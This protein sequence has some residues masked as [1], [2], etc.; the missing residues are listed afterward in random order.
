M[1]DTARPPRN[2]SPLDFVRALDTRV[3]GR[4][5]GTDATR[6][7]FHVTVPAA[8]FE[9]MD[10]RDE[11]TGW[12]TRRGLD[13]ALTDD[14]T[15]SYLTWPSPRVAPDIP[16]T[17]G[18]AIYPAREPGGWPTYVRPVILT[19]GC[20]GS[21]LAAAGDVDVTFAYSDGDP[22]TEPATWT[23]TIS[24]QDLFTVLHDAGLITRTEGK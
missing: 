2:G 9:A 13:L 3:A 21:S 6:L 24:Q 14:G 17:S 18:P 16:P 12:L 15:D 5:W 11:L 23:G 10:L 4:A 22:G 20:R 8:R 7:T 1:H 19:L